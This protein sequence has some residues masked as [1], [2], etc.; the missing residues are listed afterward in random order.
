[1]KV[2]TTIYRGDGFR[3][4]NSRRYTT[5]MTPTD[6]QFRS[7]SRSHQSGSGKQLPGQLRS[8]Y[9]G[10]THRPIWQNEPPKTTSPPPMRSGM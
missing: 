3:P 10:P 2:V 1:M 9:Q 6:G 7:A 8:R 4:N 5:A